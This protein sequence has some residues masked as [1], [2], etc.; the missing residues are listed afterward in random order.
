[1]MWDVPLG[2]K[3][4]LTGVVQQAPAPAQAIVGRAEFELKLDAGPSVCLCAY[5][6]DIPWTRLAKLATG[7]RV[8]AVTHAFCCGTLLDEFHVTSLQAAALDDA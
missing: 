5:H 7:H 8:R 2:E 1:M 4:V 6:Q 3:H